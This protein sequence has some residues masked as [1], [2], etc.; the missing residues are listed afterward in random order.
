MK[1]DNASPRFGIFGIN[2]FVS[3]NDLPS[4]AVFRQVIMVE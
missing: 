1:T 4:M 3:L 2:Y